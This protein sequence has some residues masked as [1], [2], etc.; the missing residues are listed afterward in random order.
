MDW[1][2][3]EKSPTPVVESA[4]DTRLVKAAHQ[5][6]ASMMNE[7]M[8]P[9]MENSLF[10]EDDSSALVGKGSGGS[11]ALMGFAAEALACSLSE[12]GGL[13]IARQI[14]SHLR[15]EPGGQ[16]PPPKQILDKEP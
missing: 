6:E 15:A 9:L 13:G 5:F 1:N 2:V 12:H 14:I 10:E 3:T 7:L 16:G 4:R 8:K 11:N